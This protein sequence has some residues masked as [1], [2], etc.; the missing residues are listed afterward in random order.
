MQVLVP[1]NELCPDVEILCCFFFLYV[2]RS[3]SFLTGSEGSSV[4]IPG[5]Y[6][7]LKFVSGVSNG[8]RFTNEA[9]NSRAVD[10]VNRGVTPGVDDLVPWIPEGSEL[11]SDGFTR[12]HRTAMGLLVETHYLLGQGIQELIRGNP[13]RRFMGLAAVSDQME[14]AMTRVIREMGG[15]F[16]HLESNGFVSYEAWDGAAGEGKDEDEPAE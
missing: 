5:R 13:G 4:G 15:W 6:N 3:I 1:L 14:L 2:E 10:P 16:E 11:E 9:S 7:S 12:D 8:P